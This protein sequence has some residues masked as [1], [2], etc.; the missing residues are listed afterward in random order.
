MAHYYVP[1]KH[2]ICENLDSVNISEIDT[3]KLKLKNLNN[4]DL[5]ENIYYYHESFK[6][7]EP[8]DVYVYYEHM[9]YPLLLIN[10]L[11][12]RKKFPPKINK[13]YDIKKLIDIMIHIYKND[14]INHYCLL[15]CK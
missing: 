11:L 4:F 10:Y 15:L 1:N 9:I 3:N 6:F 2:I 13:H 7:K 14:Y 5:V 12:E 8:R